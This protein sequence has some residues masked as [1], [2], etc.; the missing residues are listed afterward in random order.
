MTHHEEVASLKQR[1]AKAENERDA[2]RASGRQES[3]L[4]AYSK[5][6]A[7]E[8]Q[9][10]QLGGVQPMSIQSP[11]SDESSAALLP[12]PPDAARLMDELHISSSG[13]SFHYRGYRYDRL[14]DA[15]NY[16][17]LD[18][19]RPLEDAASVQAGPLE[20]ALLP[21]AAERELMRA[22]AITFRDGVF[23][24]RDYRYDRLADAVA[25]AKLT[26]CQ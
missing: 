14:V 7:L 26:A 4:E 24:L 11:A 20:T 10:E 22:L 25:Y 13:R 19:G 2:W 15:V 3:Y 16:A 8:V 17:R 23:H 21:T 12:Q 9:L 5:V 1:L 18:R 6:E